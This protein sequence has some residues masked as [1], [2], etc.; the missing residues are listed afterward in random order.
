MKDEL[1]RPDTDRSFNYVARDVRILRAGR[2][3]DK[4]LRLVICRR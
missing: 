1:D 3:T 2:I 4:S